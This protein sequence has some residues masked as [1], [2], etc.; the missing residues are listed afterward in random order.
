MATATAAM[1]MENT[2]VTFSP[3]ENAAPEFLMKY[4]C[5]SG[6]S[7]GIRSPSTIVDVTQIFVSWSR[8]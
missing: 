7:T 4:Q 3:M 6:G 5:N 1:M 8:T 2:H